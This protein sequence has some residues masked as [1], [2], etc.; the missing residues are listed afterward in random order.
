[1]SVAE[2]TRDVG[3]DAAPAFAE[4]LL[5]FVRLLARDDHRNRVRLIAATQLCDAERPAR[6]AR[7]ALGPA[8]IPGGRPQVEAVEQPLLEVVPP[9]HAGL[10][11][12]AVPLPPTAGQKGAREE[13]AT[14]RD[15]RGPLEVRRAEE[16]ETEI[17]DVLGAPD[18]EIPR[19]IRAPCEGPVKRL[20]N[21]NQC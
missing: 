3:L 11:G 17:A 21:V 18:G 1:M 9:L 14:R 7:G 13:G 16:L 20:K 8:E 2:Q 6:A 5:E 12:L 19:L 4:T 10:L 15:Q